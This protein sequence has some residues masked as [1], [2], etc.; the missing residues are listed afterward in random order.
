MTRPGGSAAGQKGAKCGPSLKAAADSSLGRV[1]SLVRALGLLD[2]IARAGRLTLRDLARQTGLPKSTV[3]RLLTT[4]EALRY[5]AFDRETNA[6]SIGV[7]AFTMGSAFARAH[8]VGQAGRSIMQS[9]SSQFGHC[10]SLAMAEGDGICHVDQIAIAAD[11]QS[12]ARPGTVLPFHM[13]A[14]GKVVMASWS[15]ARLD[16]YL[17]SAPLAGRTA[18]SLVGATQLRE[19]LAEVRE[20]GFAL[21]DEEYDEGLRCVAAMVRGQPG[22]P[23]R[24]LSLSDQS[25][26]LSR[27]RLGLLGPVLLNAAGQMAAADMLAMP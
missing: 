9:L 24:A 21:D 17:D 22:G 7:Q 4:M 20:R 14:S 18:N 27:D 19:Q 6:W 26:R 16:H 3:H 13:T 23:A 8:D 2:E 15:P 1:Q 25:A 11:R 12:A 5:V 10:V